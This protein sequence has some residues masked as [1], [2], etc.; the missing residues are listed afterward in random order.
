MD[1]RRDLPAR[2]ERVTDTGLIS[3][4]HSSSRAVIERAAIE[5]ALERAKLAAA[6]RELRSK[7]YAPLL[8]LISQDAEAQEAWK[9]L[10]ELIAQSVERRKNLLPVRSVT[11]GWSSFDLHPNLNMFTPPYDLDAVNEMSGPAVTASADRVAAAVAVGLGAGDHD[12][13]ARV[14][15]AQISIVLRSSTAGVLRFCPWLNYQWS[16]AITASFCLG[17]EI[18]GN[19]ITTVVENGRL[20]GTQNLR[21]FSATDGVASE[22]GSIG[23]ALEIY[24]PIE[25][26]RN[27]VCSVTATIWGDQSGSGFLFGDSSFSNGRVRLEVPMLVADL[28]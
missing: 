13:G 7:A 21:L 10:R 24:F 16:Y 4:A 20:V 15:S 14:A 26:G 22:T 25:P 9:S 12:G 5:P 6:D 19:V 27:Y 18:E 28:R 17:A 8:R 11:G 2:L 23:S 1:L 3:E